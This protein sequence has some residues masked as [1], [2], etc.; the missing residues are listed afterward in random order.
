MKVLYYIYAYDICLGSC[1]I[2][3]FRPVATIPQNDDI[4]GI[5]QE[6]S[7]SIADARELRLSCTNPSIC[8]DVDS[9][10]EE[11]TSPDAYVRH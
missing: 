8:P 5:L 6:R 9:W 2:D 1:H 4:D 11:Q 3:N 7:N 10:D